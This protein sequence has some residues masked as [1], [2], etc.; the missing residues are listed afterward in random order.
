[1]T[2]T[3]VLNLS[4]GEETY[5][6]VPHPSLMTNTSVLNLSGGEETYRRVPHPSLMTNTS[7]LNLSGGSSSSTYRVYVKELFDAK[8]PQIS[9][10]I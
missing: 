2:N 4:G 3:S 5:R 1:M 10:A 6:R 8:S 7:V 9:R